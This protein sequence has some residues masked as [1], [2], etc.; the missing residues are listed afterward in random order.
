MRKA[1][2]RTLFWEL[3]FFRKAAAHKVAATQF[4]RD[5]KTS[6]VIR[7]GLIHALVQKHMNQ[8]TMSPEKMPERTGSESD[9]K[10]GL[11]KQTDPPV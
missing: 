5:E 8:P 9:K 3:P 7:V 1:I 6:G 4:I 10:V 2:A 11:P